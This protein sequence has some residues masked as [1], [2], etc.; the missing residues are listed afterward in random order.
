MRTRACCLQIVLMCAIVSLQVPVAAAIT[1]DTAHE[2]ANELQVREIVLKIFE[3]YALSDWMFTDRIVIDNTA[4]IPHS[5]PLLTLN[6]RYLSDETEILTNIIHEQLHWFLGEHQSALRAAIVDMRALYPA[7]PDGPPRGGRNRR[8][9]ELHLV[10]C[11]LEYLALEGRS[12]AKQLRKDCWTSRTTPGSLLPWSKIM[13]HCVKFST[14][15][16]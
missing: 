9:T 16:V 14:G 6:T 1:V 13:R 3:Q 12:A 8:S 4:P 2:D 11:S 15:T 7:M 10:V 5:H